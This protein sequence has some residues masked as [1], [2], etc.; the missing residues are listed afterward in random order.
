MGA[1]SLSKVFHQKND[2]ICSPTRDNTAWSRFPALSD[3]TISRRFLWCWGNISQSVFRSD[4]LSFPSTGGPQPLWHASSS[5][6]KFLVAWIFSSDVSSSE[7]SKTV[8]LFLRLETGSLLKMVR[9]TCDLDCSLEGVMH[10][11]ESFALPS[12]SS[13]E[14]LESRLHL[15]LRLPTHSDL[16]A[17]SL[18]PGC[19]GRRDGGVS[20]TIV[21]EALFGV[22]H[23]RQL[24][25]GQFS[26][27][28][29]LSCC[30]YPF[31]FW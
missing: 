5:T 4:S 19:T 9:G 16:H 11:L 23:G 2:L 12:S 21:G 14:L 6:C 24:S 8:V 25:E 10:S 26:L 28:P 1:L 3:R 29:T 15:F 7:S 30:E 31:L 18:E 27:F 17:L 22:V 20:G 13:S